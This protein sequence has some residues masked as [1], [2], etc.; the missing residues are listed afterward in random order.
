M[1]FCTHCGRQ[2]VDGANYCFECGAKVN[3]QSSPHIEQRKT[4]YEGELHKCPNCGELLNAFEISCSACGYELRGSRATNA[5]RELSS[6][7]EAIEKSREQTQS[8]SLI[9]KLY[10]SDGQI[11]KTDEQK[12]SLIRSF[13][14]PNNKEDIFEF[15]ILAASNI[16]LKLYGL[17]NQGIITASQRA[18]SDAW[19]AKFE[20]AYQKAQLSIGTTPEFHSINEIYKEKM[21]ALKHAKLQVPLLIAGLICLPLIILLLLLVF[22]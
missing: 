5:V 16:D 3:T 6:K 8:H 22:M 18:V 14:I 1:A 20:Q 21:K 17:G 13:S 9:G 7:L 19:L 15:M 4:V 10:G 12:I 2:L 11:G